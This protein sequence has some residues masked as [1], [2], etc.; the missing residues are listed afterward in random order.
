MKLTVL[1]TSGAYPGPGGACS[2]YLVEDRGSVLLLDCGTGVLA[3]LQKHISIHDLSHIVITHMHADHFLDLVPLRYALAFGPKRHRISLHLP[4][5]GIQVLQSVVTFLKDPSFF[6]S[7]FDLEEYAP[8]ESAI[9]GFKIAIAPVPH[10]IPS[11]AVA[12]AN[13]RKLTF[14]SDCGPSDSLAAVAAG[15]DLLLTEALL[16]SPVEKVPRG[17]LTMAEAAQIA[18]RARVA[19]LVFSHIY[20]DRDYSDQL[21]QAKKEFTGPVEIAGINQTYEV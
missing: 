18:T 5:G 10:Y 4:P 12:V 6:P 8:G 19:R 7:F 1:G 15:S 16:L 13:T 20:P 17:H 14:S 11:H 3:N 9:L 2:G 21:A